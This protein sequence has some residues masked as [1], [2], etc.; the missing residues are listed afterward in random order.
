[1]TRQQ[2]LHVHRGIVAG[3]MLV[4]IVL[5]ATF[6]TV[7]S[8][9]VSHAAVRRTATLAAPLTTA[10]EA[11]KAAGALGVRRTVLVAGAAH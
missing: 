10:V 5:L 8:G 3:C 9:V 2:P 1:M 4:A 11:G 6:Y 7:V